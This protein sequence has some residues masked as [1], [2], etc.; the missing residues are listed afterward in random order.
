LQQTYYDHADLPAW[1]LEHPYENNGTGSALWPSARDPGTQFSAYERVIRFFCDLYTRPG[2][3]EDVLA[4]VDCRQSNKDFVSKKYRMTFGSGVEGGGGRRRDRRRVAGGRLEG[5]R[6]HS[7]VIA[8]PP[9][10][11][12]LGMG[13]ALL[14]DGQHDVVGHGVAGQVR[15]GCRQRGLRIV[16]AVDV[17][18]HHRPDRGRPAR[19]ARRPFRRSPR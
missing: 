16:G 9:V 8:D 1:T 18:G 15:D 14:Q 19:P 11:T 7:V 6:H 10:A 2:A 13:G 12:G 3:L 17:V 4:G 5:H